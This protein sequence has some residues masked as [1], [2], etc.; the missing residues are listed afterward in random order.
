MS[1]LGIHFHATLASMRDAQT[2][3][4]SQ[5][6]SHSLCLISEPQL[7]IGSASSQS[8]LCGAVEA[9]N[10]AFCGATVAVVWNAKIQP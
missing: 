7:A 4:K 6:D 1:T 3:T 2:E 5:T 9:K 8:S 10:L